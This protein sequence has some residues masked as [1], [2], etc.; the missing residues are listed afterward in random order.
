MPWYNNVTGELI[1][2]PSDD[3][4][5][6][7]ELVYKP[8]IYTKEELPTWSEV[9]EEFYLN[10]IYSYDPNN[11]DD[12][13]ED[14]YWKIPHKKYL[15]ATICNQFNKMLYED[16]LM[17]QVCSELSKEINYEVKALQFICGDF[18]KSEI[19]YD[20]KIFNTFFDKIYE[21]YT[22][23][24]PTGKQNPFIISDYNRINITETNEEIYCIFPIIKFTHNDSTALHLLDLY[25]DNKLF[26]TVIEIMIKLFKDY[27]SGDIGWKDNNGELIEGD[28]GYRQCFGA[29]YNIT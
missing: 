3:M 19:V 28:P 14:T 26:H 10:K 20:A 8:S 22:I 11:P 5:Q 17:N 29:G 27:F 23:P 1:K 9:Y 15:I 12:Q 18:Y 16:G 6:K 4:K 24:L 13:V 7:D 25:I 2:S 21:I